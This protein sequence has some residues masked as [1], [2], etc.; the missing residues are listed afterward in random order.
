MTEPSLT[1]DPG[2]FQPQACD[3]GTPSPVRD[4]ARYRNE[5]MLASHPDFPP[6][7]P[8]AMEVTAETSDE[9]LDRFLFGDYGG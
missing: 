8:S 9:E 7:G 4:A 6:M 3:G 5:I 1:D 2:G